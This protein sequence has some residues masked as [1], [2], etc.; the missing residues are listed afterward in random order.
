MYFFGPLSYVADLIWSPTDLSVLLTPAVSGQVDNCCQPTGFSQLSVH[1]PGTTC[2]TTWHPPS[3]YPASV[4][5]SRLTSSL[6]LFF[7]LFPGLIL[8][9]VVNFVFLLPHEWQ[10]CIKQAVNWVICVICVTYQCV[11]LL[12][13]QH[14]W[15]RLLL[16][17]LCVRSLRAQVL[18]RTLSTAS[19]TWSRNPTSA[20]SDRRR[21]VSFR[22]HWLPLAKKAPVHFAYKRHY[23]LF[24][25]LFIC[26]RYSCSSERIFSYVV[27]LILN[28][29]RCD[30]K[31][32]KLRFRTG[33]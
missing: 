25:M 32:A 28:P 17:S 12:T 11:G 18:Q 31:V 4:S 14:R 23:T 5:D 15:R 2:Q 7:W 8:S 26:I 9:A 1:G 22:Q 6:N 29:Q 24:S 21:R 10:W 13:V 16:L 30:V 27:I 3:H 19:H 20:I 33:H